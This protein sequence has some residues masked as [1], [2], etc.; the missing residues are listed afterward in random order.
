MQQRKLIINN[1]SFDKRCFSRGAEKR[2]F[3]VP[4]SSV[5]EPLWDSGRD[6]ERRSLALRSIAH[7]EPSQTDQDFPVTVLSQQTRVRL[8]EEKYDRRTWLRCS[9]ARRPYISRM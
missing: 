4:E 8:S 3:G 6:V 5:R 2:F 7:V 1:P 9:K